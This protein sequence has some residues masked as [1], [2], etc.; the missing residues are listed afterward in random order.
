MTA[1]ELL[2]QINPLIPALLSGGVQDWGNVRPL[3]EDVKE[4]GW[5]GAMLS[6]ETRRLVER[7]NEVLGKIR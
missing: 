2:L 3:S 7:A 6:P 4:F 5:S 1:E